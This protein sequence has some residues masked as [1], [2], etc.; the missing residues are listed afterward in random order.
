MKPAGETDVSLSR[1]WWTGER[2]ERRSRLRALDD[3]G[4]EALLED[5]EGLLPIER[6]SILLASFMVGP[7]GAAL[8]RSQVRE[9][10]IGDR[11]TL[12]LSLR[13][14]LLGKVMQCILQCPSCP[15]KMDLQLNLDDLIVSADH[16]PET[17]YDDV[18]EFGAERLHVSF[19][20]P[21]ASDVEAAIQVS[22]GV[23]EQAVLAL[24]RRCIESVTRV[25]TDRDLP[26]AKLDEIDW[27]ADLF[28]EISARIEKLDAQ[29]EIKLSLVCPDCGH[30]F[31]TCLDP[32]EFL[33]RELSERQRMKHHEVH[34]LAKAY[35]W[36]EAD[37]LRM[38]PRKRQIYLD[39][40]EADHE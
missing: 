38:G 1:G 30:A 11:T 18:V 22:R 9:L 8:N 6:D 27:P 26:P 12:L 25:V 5:C 13:R 33:V 2:W 4:E 19:H 24:G 15:G 20:L 32:G 7:A 28:P 10:S 21:A 23:P 36:S 31:E 39:L 37:I 17:H 16:E 34:L 3:Y 29:A 14:L 35:H 40:L